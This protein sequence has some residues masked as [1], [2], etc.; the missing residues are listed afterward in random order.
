MAQSRLK[1]TQEKKQK[2]RFYWS[3]VLI[4]LIGIGVGSVA[5]L[6]ITSY[7]AK[8]EES[9]KSATAPDSTKPNKKVPL[10]PNNSVKANELPEKAIDEYLKNSGFVGSVYIEDK[11][12]F[13]LEK[14]YGYSDL[15]SGRKNTTSSV[16]YI[17]SM[18]KA[19][20][21]TAFMQL[22]ERGLV[23][24]DDPI[25]KYIPSF[26]NGQ[27]IK[28]V[29]FLGHT[30]GMK[31][32]HE[33]NNPIT[34]YRIIR[35]IEQAGIKT[36]PGKWQY[37]DDNYSV[38]AYLIQTISG[39]EFENYME[40]HIFIPAGMSGAGFYT[41]YNINFMHTESYLREK[42]KIIN[43]PVR[44]DLSQLFGAG[45][46]YMATQDIKKFDDA[47]LGGKLV[48]KESVARML[49]KGPGKYGFGFY[50]LGNHYI[51]RGVLAGYEAGNAFT[52]DRKKFVILLSNARTKAKTDYQYTQ[53]ILAIMNKN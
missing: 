18:Q 20:V 34:P 25:A 2:H 33:G 29:N 13:V 31:P 47:L 12:K 45:D 44:Q 43:A 35:E 19:M 40:Q 42:G 49:K 28:I 14:G 50:D 32:R 17:G 27:K 26:P 10:K 24:L 4:L 53:D 15:A 51:A 7:E 16:Y 39:V 8:N 38:I 22:V 41:T 6:F 37:A 21:A 48:G 23:R 9:S 1:K 30:T 11:G 5:S 3:L 46:I 36:Q 52:K